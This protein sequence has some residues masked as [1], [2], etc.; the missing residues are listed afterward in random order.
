MELA[1]KIGINEL[2]LVNWEIK[3]MVPRIK[4]LREKLIQEVEGRGGSK[5]V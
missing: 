2:T 1:W 5:N 4:N 3:G